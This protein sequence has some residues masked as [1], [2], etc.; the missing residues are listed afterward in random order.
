MS[1]YPQALGSIP[2]ETGR[3]ARAA[4][5][6]GTLAMRLR[7]SLGEL[8]QD[9]QFAA[10]YP[11]EGQPAY[12]PWRLAIVTV[13]QYAAGLTDRQ[14][15]DAVRERI[16]WKYALALELTD[17]GFDFSL[18]SEFRLR[19]VEGGAET[20]LLDRLLEVCKQ[21]GWLKAGGKQRTDS[22]HVLARVRSLS[23]LECVGET[24]RAT[25]DD[26]ASVAPEWLVRHISPEW[27]ERYGHRVENYRLPKAESQRTS[28]AQQIG[29]D[30]LH[31]LQALEQADAPG[32]LKEIS[33]V[34]VLRQV[35]HQY[36]DLAGG[37][38]RWRAGPQAKD[39]EGIIRSPYDVEAQ[40]GKKREVTWLGYKVHLTE[41]CAL[42]EGE[43]AEA[44]ACPHLI[45]QVQTTVAPVQ[46]VEMTATIQEELATRDLL[47]E[48]QFVDTGYVDAQLLVSSQQKHG[49][50]L[51]GPVLADNSWQA[52]EGR[53]F[54]VAHFQLDWQ[55][56]QA[57]CPQ[58]Q[59]SSRWSVAGER[60]EV[61]FPPEICAQCPVRSECTHSQTTGRVLHLRPQEA[62]EA[63]HAR[64]HEQQTPQF[65]QEYATRA[66]M[67][68]T[69]SQA[70]RGKGL[71]RARYD[72]L[73]KTQLQHVLIAVAINLERIDAVLTHTPRGKT[74]QSHLERLASHPSWQGQIGA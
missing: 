55:N 34:Q 59:L 2:E 48:E 13:L 62:H 49:I 7:D 44:A 51:V 6:Q 8:Y 36:Y 65:R 43:Q 69:L 70:V 28:L 17:P 64:R 5:P 11:V 30:G 31:L 47:P 72:G 22:T 39:K 21:R 12:A 37:Q 3:V 71:R 40:T 18:L 42:E 15:A 20:L 23:N 46:D 52:K 50:R 54:D 4:C 10:L 53:G 33:S 74:R 57:T 24:L 58:G 66:G 26:L 63:L 29:A 60:M 41:T 35:W 45:V 25:L 38:A 67:E 27:L 32:D 1:M 73:H 61:V 19:L 56:Q 16:D 68:A 14:A 9:E